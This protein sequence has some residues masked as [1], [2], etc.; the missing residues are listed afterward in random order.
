MGVERVVSMNEAPKKNPL[1]APGKYYVT[2]D[3]LACEVCVDDAP[4]IFRMADGM[5]HVYKQP[6]TPE[7]ER[8]CQE[9]INTC[10]VEAIRDDG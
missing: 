9:A 5:S 10:C 4:N 3:C 6:A 1:N 7:E 8:Q 2:E